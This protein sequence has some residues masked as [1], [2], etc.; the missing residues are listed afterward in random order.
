MDRIEFGRLPTAQ[1][2]AES[3]QEAAARLRSVLEESVALHALADAPVGAFLSSGVDSTGIVAL[4]R[5]HVRRLRT[6]SL[7]W[8]EGGAPDETAEAESTAWRLGCEHTSVRV[9]G[10]EVAEV[11][12]SFARALDQPSVDG[13]NTWFVSR[14]AARDVKG[15]LSGL[16]GDEWFAGYAVVSRMALY[17]IQRL[18]ADGS[19]AR[20][21]RWANAASSPMRRRLQS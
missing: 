13:L 17:W 8:A 3:L 10:R 19:P 15:V 11:L 7:G 6:Y 14:G 9:S 18:T 21:L 20:R 16:G 12:P 5:R 4:M 1:P 2:R